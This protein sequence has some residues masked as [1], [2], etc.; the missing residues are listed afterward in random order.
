MKGLVATT[1]DPGLVFPCLA[2]NN[3]WV[4]VVFDE[5]VFCRHTPSSAS[6]KSSLHLLV[7]NVS[8]VS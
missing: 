3:A 4:E 2:L 1:T 5:N 7:I 8:Y 6:R